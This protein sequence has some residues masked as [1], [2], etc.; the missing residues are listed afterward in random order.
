MLFS[1]NMIRTQDCIYSRGVLYEHQ[2]SIEPKV[3]RKDII[4]AISKEVIRINVIN[5][6][7][8]ADISRDVTRVMVTLPWCQ[9][10]QGMP[11]D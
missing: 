10:L 5:T 3:G 4:K 8:G 6:I 9:I 2:W 1:R 7:S 11:L